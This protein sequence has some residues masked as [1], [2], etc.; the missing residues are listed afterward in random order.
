MKCL[1]A[2]EDIAGSYTMVHIQNRQS[3]ICSG[4]PISQLVQRSSS[5]SCG[6]P[7]TMIGGDLPALHTADFLGERWYCEKKIQ[8]AKV[9]VAA[10]SGKKTVWL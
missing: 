1:H 9:K 6:G 8:S 3:V 5:S 10:K 2:V 7:A 4:A